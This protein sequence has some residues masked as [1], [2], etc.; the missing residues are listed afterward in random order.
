M[1]AALAGCDDGIDEGGGDPGFTYYEVFIEAAASETSGASIELYGWA[2]CDA[3]PPSESWF[4]ACPPI[5]GPFASAIGIGWANLTTGASGDAFHGIFGR[6]SWFFSYCT[7]FYSHRWSAWI[8]L[9]YGPNELELTAFGPSSLP[10]R[11]RIQVTR[12][13]GVPADVTAETAAGMVTLS[14]SSVPEAEA[15]EVLW[16]DVPDL[17]LPGTNVVLVQASPF[18]HT[19]LADDVTYHYAVRALAQGYPGPLSP[20]VLGTPGWTSDAVPIPVLGG[21]LFDASLALDSH[22]AAHVHVSRNDP[23]SFARLVNHYATDAGGTWSVLEVSEVGSIAADVALDAHDEVH[24]AYL[25]S[26]TGRHARLAGSTWLEE[27]FA[28]PAD[29]YVGLRLDA[30]GH[31]HA[32]YQTHVFQPS[33]LGQLEWATDTS[34]AWDVEVVD[35]TYFGC[36]QEGARLELELDAEQVPH[37]LYVGEEPALGLRYATRAGGTWSAEEVAPGYVRGLSLALDAAGT[38]HAAWT[39]DAG[40]L[41]HA[42]REAP[43]VWTSEEIDVFAFG[44]SLGV[45]AQGTLHLSYAQYVSDE[46]RYARRSSGPWQLVSIGPADTAD[47]ALAVEPGGRAHIVYSASGVV[48]HAVHR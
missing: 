38:P 10:G 43:G 35:R 33:Q 15:Y 26:S 36:F 19:G 13:P 31:A 47:T 8:P 28:S 20:T 21:G 5:Q 39:S 25:D 22:G 14:W 6:Q 37:A 40:H 44:P 32:L 12:L 30:L 41:Y 2:S 4:G 46:L 45:D 9:A 29:C 16:A 27:T 24:V 3:C 1:L 23:S 17:S 7:V 34:G 11:D 18:V 42:R 48:R